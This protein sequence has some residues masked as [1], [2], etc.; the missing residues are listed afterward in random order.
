MAVMAVLGAGGVLHL[1]LVELVAWAYFG[2]M[3]AIVGAVV[4]ILALSAPL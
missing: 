2:T 1:S 3:L 4:L